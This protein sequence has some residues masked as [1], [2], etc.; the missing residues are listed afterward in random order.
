MG[1]GR[2]AR[3]ISDG[4]NGFVDIPLGQRS[5]GQH[6]AAP[7]MEM[8]MTIWAVKN[9]RPAG[10]TETRHCPCHP[11][12]KVSGPEGGFH[13]PGSAVYSQLG[14]DWRTGDWHVKDDNQFGYRVVSARKLTTNMEQ[15]REREAH[16]SAA[17]AVAP[18]VMDIDGGNGGGLEH[19]RHAP[20]HRRRHHRCPPPHYPHPHLRHHRHH[21][22]RCPLF[23]RSSQRDAR[24]GGGCHRRAST[25]WGLYR[26]PGAETSTARCAIPESAAQGAVTACTAR[27]GGA[28]PSGRGC[29]PRSPTASLSP[30]SAGAP[31]TPG[32]RPLRL[33][34]RTTTQTRL[35]E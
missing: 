20:P 4:A 30:S 13:P 2:G 8:R 21:H 35:W 12:F 23:R 17:A 15:E 32:R 29:P 7:P 31:P 10:N 28:G 11:F 1:P 9:L 34:C 33:R 14:W 16:E 3:L 25:V 24:M 18:G 26:S 5:Q 19:S 6:Y 22:L 27:A